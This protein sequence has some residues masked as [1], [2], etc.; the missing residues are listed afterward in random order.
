MPPASS[1]RDQQAA[2]AA[3]READHEEERGHRGEQD[4]GANQV[5]RCVLLSSGAAP[6]TATSPRQRTIK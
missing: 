3:E 2:L 5:H 1:K 4:A 6:P